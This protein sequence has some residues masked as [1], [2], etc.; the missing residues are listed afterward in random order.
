MDKRYL[1]PWTK[2]IGHL[3]SGL[4]HQNITE[5][6]KLWITN[7]KRLNFIPDWW[8]TREFWNWIWSFLLE[9]N[10]LT[11]ILISKFWIRL[12]GPLLPQPVY[13]HCVVELDEEN[14]LLIGGFTESKTDK[15][16]QNDFAFIFVLKSVKYWLHILRGLKSF[17]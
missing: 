14:F 6:D 11:K 15:G 3:T 16:K 4:D 9:V 12:T 10:T 7:F 17:V 13:F 2:R 8:K 5:G 1:G